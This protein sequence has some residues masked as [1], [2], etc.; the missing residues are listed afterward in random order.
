[1]NVSTMH[2]I[3]KKPGSYEFALLLLLG[4]LWG[5]PYAL[6]KISLTTIPPMTL[7]AVRVVLAA[8]TL[9]IVVLASGCKLPE[10]RDF[11]PRMLLQGCISCIIPYAFIA[12]GQQTVPSALTAILNSTG[13]LFVCLISL[14]WTRHERTTVGRLIGIATGLGGVL[15]V[16]G[17]GALT[18]LGRSTIGQSAIIL[19]TLSSALSVIHGRRFSNIPPE[20]AAAGTLTAAALVL[21]PLSFAFEAPL[22]CTPSAVSILA[23]LVNAV[24][25]T[26]FGFVVYFRLIH[27]IGSL[28]TASVGYLRPAIG[29]VIG[30]LL[31]HET[32]SWTQM[33]GLAAILCGVAS[34]HQLK[35]GWLGTWLPLKRGIRPVGQT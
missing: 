26:A 15:L 2:K 27:T 30:C 12:F 9:W 13:P 16:F 23:L 11:I 6:T 35:S 25:A 28:G 21:V 18:D 29:V 31:M 22:S 19:A 32:V 33:A 14:V 3:E 4:I 7:T 1:M 8:V 24:V 5:I 17:T 20:I 34:I 10:H